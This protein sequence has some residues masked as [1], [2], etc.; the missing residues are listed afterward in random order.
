MAAKKAKKGK[1]T[2]AKK[3]GKTTA[4]KTKKAPAKRAIAIKVAGK[5]VE[6]KSTP[7]KTMKPKST[8]AAKPAKVMTASQPASQPKVKLGQPIKAYALAATGNQEVDLANLKGKNVVLYFYPKD[9]TPG[10]TL[11]GKEFTRLKND[12]ESANTTVYGISRDSVESHEKFKD[13]YGYTIDLLSDGEEKLC[14][15]FGVIQPKNMYGKI[16]MGI[17]RSTFVID[18]DGVLRREWRKVSVPGHADE[19]LDFVKSL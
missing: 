11:E 18:K 10:C 16:S 1:K 15:E 8:S 7:V 12:F 13:K 6:G 5:K 2:A 19:V 17:E 4:K 14:N 3:T 9:D